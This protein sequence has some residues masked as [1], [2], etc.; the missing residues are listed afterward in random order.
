MLI[1]ERFRRSLIGTSLAMSLIIPIGW[2]EA[3]AQSSSSSSPVAVTTDPFEMRGAA[4][5][6]GKI[7][8]EVPLSVG[9][10]AAIK[11]KDRTELYLVSQNGR[12]IMRG[13]VYDLWEG[14]ELDTLDAIKN[15]TSNVGL[16]G[17]D[18]VLPQVAPM[19]VGDG[20]RRIELF[21]DPYCPYCK[22]LLE[23]LP[24]ALATKRFTFVILPVPLL[25][26]R[27]TTEVRALGCAVD[28]KAALGQLLA[29]VYDPPLAQVAKCDVL[30]MEKRFVLAR[31]LNISA[32]PFIVRDDGTEQAGLPDEDLVT[33]LG[34]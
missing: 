14:K 20:P 13:P 12:Y 29:H 8:Q 15:S 34:N 25:G 10:F 31:M 1:A 32:V 27:S 9:Q 3:V 23:E 5:L 33:W 16:G 4:A 6:N 2:S 11:V 28:Q 18:K 26:D 30:P 19:V 21:V 24:A 17:F 7:E 22:R